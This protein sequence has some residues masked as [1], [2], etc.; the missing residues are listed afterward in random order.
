MNL[1]ILP[2]AIYYRKESDTVYI[3]AVLDCRRDPGLT[4]EKLK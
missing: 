4:R 1:R 3:D 2:S